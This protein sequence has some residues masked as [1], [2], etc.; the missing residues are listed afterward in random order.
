LRRLLVCSLPDAKVGTSPVLQGIS[1]NYPERKGRFLTCYSPVRRS[2]ARRPVA[3][4]ACLIHAASVRPEPGS[5]SPL[6]N[7][8]HD[9]EIAFRLTHLCLTK[10][11]HLH[12]SKPISGFRLVR[13]KR[14][15]STIQFSKNA[16]LSRFS[17]AFRSTLSQRARRNFTSLRS[18][19]S[20]LPSNFFCWR[21]GITRWGFNY[22]TL[23]LS[24]FQPFFGSFSAPF[25]FA[26]K[27]IGA[28]LL[29]GQREI[30]RVF[31]SGA[32]GESKISP[33]LFASDFLPSAGAPSNLRRSILAPL[34]SQKMRC[35][36]QR[37]T[38]SS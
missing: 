4:L 17:A 30:I 31:S 29:E 16:P 7:G 18:I 21:F 33:I 23:S 25:L 10:A 11:S 1:S 20:T 36:S 38:Y 34:L 28:P 14:F 35:F 8:S 12:L 2:I 32:R 26:R 15:K 37:D 22:T 3:R 24:G 13:N 5:N 6:K 9:L 19:L 27:N